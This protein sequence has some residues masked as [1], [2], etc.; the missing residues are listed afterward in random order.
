[1]GQCI[2]FEDTERDGSEN[3]ALIWTR[4]N[5]RSGFLNEPEEEKPSSRVGE[6]KGEEGDQ[7]KGRNAIK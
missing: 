1:L 3:A 7:E 5:A 6:R 2:G 4:R